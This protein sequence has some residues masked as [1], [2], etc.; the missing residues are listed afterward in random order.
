MKLKDLIKLPKKKRISKDNPE[1]YQRYC[2]GYNKCLIE[3][4]NLIIPDEVIRFQKT[5]SPNA[6]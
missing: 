5:K 3:I 1:P 2:K 6:D 4:Q